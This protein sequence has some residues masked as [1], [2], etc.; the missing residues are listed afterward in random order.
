MAVGL[1]TSVA[2]APDGVSFAADTDLTIRRVRQL[3]RS[4]QLL[5]ASAVAT[6]IWLRLTVVDAATGYVVLTAL[7]VPVVA[8]QWGLRRVRADNVVPLVLGLLA[9][10]WASTL[11]VAPLAPFAFPIMPFAVIVPLLAAGPIF[12]GPRLRMLIAGGTVVMV[13]IGVLALRWSSDAIDDDIPPA[14]QH[15]IVISALAM[16]VV[17]VSFAVLDA[18]RRRYASMHALES[19]NAALRAANDSL[20]ASR[21]RV[22]T[23]ADEERRRIERDLHDGAQ[24][25]LI[26]LS[27]RL[28]LVGSRHPEA[29][30][31]VTTL[32]DDLGGAIETLRELAHGIYPPLLERRGLPGALAAACRRSPL[33]T[34]LE[35]ADVARYDR[36]RERAL[37][38]R[39]RSPAERGEVR[40]TRQL[41]SSPPVRVRPHP[42]RSCART[43]GR[44]RRCRVRTRTAP[45]SRPRPPEHGRSPGSHRR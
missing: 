36:R 25:Q 13:A 9:F 2:G 41:G 3:F 37:L 4:E 10:Y 19:A 16:R 32:A 44:R 18:N 5:A 43:R 7:A 21:A 12:E 6:A 1:T 23:A 27:L 20:Q 31:D 39:P 24:Q 42:H 40:R 14:T 15:A 11:V 26:A 35:A 30:D 28:G 8:T 17:T 34:T 38:R 29:A 33:D 22:V 45:R